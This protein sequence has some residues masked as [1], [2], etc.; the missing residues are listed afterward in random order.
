M[1]KKAVDRFHWNGN[2]TLRH[3]SVSVHAGWLYVFTCSMTRDEAVSALVETWVYTKKLWCNT[4]CL[5][6][7]CID[8]QLGSGVIESQRLEQMSMT[9]SCHHDVPESLWK[10]GSVLNQHGDLACH[11][12]IAWVWIRSPGN[13]AVRV[14]SVSLRWSSP[15]ISGFLSSSS[16]QSVASFLVVGCQHFPD[17]HLC[18]LHTDLY[19]SSFV[20]CW[21][22]AWP[23]AC[24]LLCHGCSDVNLHAAPKVLK[25]R[26]DF[27][28]SA[29][30][31]EHVRFLEWFQTYKQLLPFA[32]VS[33]LHL[34]DHRGEAALVGGDEEAQAAEKEEEEGP[35]WASEACLGLRT[36]LQ[37]HAGCH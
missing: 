7:R 31:F 5:K 35:K 27:L 11:I 23:P 14:W 36:L 32:D 6:N 25:S 24:F 1:L 18:R 28:L 20:Q 16:S 30:N 19:F 29:S 15:R 33:P 21:H 8:P 22:L 9:T 4:T 37:G 17:C 12:L 26:E 2:V 34:S 3:G 13:G 10:D